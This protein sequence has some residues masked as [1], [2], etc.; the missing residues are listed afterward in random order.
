M[1]GF[2]CFSDHILSLPPP[3]MC[4]YNTNYH[5][6][7]KKF[8]NKA[9]CIKNSIKVIVLSEVESRGKKKL[10]LDVLN[11]SFHFLLLCLFFCS[12]IL[13]IFFYLAFLFFFLSFYLFFSFT[14]YFF[15]MLN[16]LFLYKF[17][18]FISIL[19]V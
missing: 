10:H 9:V 7:K 19:I 11:F 2:P 14:F 12:L 13:I 16:I 18:H 5:V 3:A 8:M 1:T 6:K 15:F 4:F 17:Y